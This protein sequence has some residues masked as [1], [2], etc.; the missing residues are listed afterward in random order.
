MFVVEAF[1]DKS[2]SMAFLWPRSCRPDANAVFVEYN[3]SDLG[4]A[5]D[6]ALR[7]MLENEG[8]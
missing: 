5:N 7:L 3:D 1:V 8:V 2:A 6:D 4:D